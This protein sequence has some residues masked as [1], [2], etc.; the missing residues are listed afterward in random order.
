VEVVARVL[1]AI[2][3]VVVGRDMASKE[4]EDSA[5]EGGGNDEV[6]NRKY[7]IE[8]L[9]SKFEMEDQIEDDKEDSKTIVWY[10][11]KGG[12]KN[13]AQVAVKLYDASTNELV[14]GMNDLVQIDLIFANDSIEVPNSKGGQAALTFIPASPR[15]RD[16][17]CQIACKIHAV[18]KKHNDRK[19]AIRVS[20]PKL[21][22]SCVVENAHKRKYF[23]MKTKQKS[24]WEATKERKRRRDEA[25]ANEDVDVAATVV[26]AESKPKQTAG[27]LRNKIDDL[28]KK[29]SSLEREIRTMNGA[30]PNVIKAILKKEFEKERNAIQKEIKSIFQKE[31]QKERKAR[32]QEQAEL[33]SFLAKERSKMT[34]ELMK[35]LKDERGEIKKSI[36]KIHVKGHQRRVKERPSATVTSPKRDAN[37]RSS[38]TRSSGSTERL[39]SFPSVTAL[40][41][42]STA[43]QSKSNDTGTGTGSFEQLKEYEKKHGLW[44]NDM[45]LSLM[46]LQKACRRSE[47][48]WS[49][50][51]TKRGREVSDVHGTPQ[52]PN[53][54]RSK[55]PTGP[56]RRE[57]GGGATK[58]TGF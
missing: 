14:K 52:G 49:R 55:V 24:E 35:M 16:G 6:L 29:T 15:L 32:K 28:K 37:E 18:T 12:K 17:F 48:P 23:D 43:R 41:G 22:V 2:R 50:E 11:T 39:L 25:E 54:K 56:Q 9:I 5:Q 40:R 19:F 47:G 8:A 33:K 34:K 10:K 51:G 53:T 31:F 36:K 1:R 58:R 7:R 26:D 4:I 30:L 13:H 46:S 38:T 3:N 42:S 20:I 21:N 57:D 45:A 44:R 27:L